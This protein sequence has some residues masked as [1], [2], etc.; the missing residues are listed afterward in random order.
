MWY[1]VNVTNNV[2][3]NNVAGWDGAGIS[4]QDALAVN[5]INNTIASNDTTASSGVL[6]NTLGAPLASS[7]GPTC[8]SNCGTTSKPQ[9][10]GVVSIQ[11]SAVLTANLPANTTCPAT[12][13]NC[14]KVSYPLLENNVFWQNRSFYIG[15]GPLGMGTLNQQNVVSLFNAFSNTPAA[16]QPKADATT[17]NGAG[18]IVTGGSGACDLTISANHFWDLGVRGDTGPENH[19]SGVTLNPTYSVITDI[20]A[21]T[22]YNANSA[23][24]SAGNPTFLSQYCNGSRV[25]PELGAMGYQV[26]PGISDAQVPNPV[27]NLT[28]AATIDEGNNWIN[29]SWGPLSMFQPINGKVLGNYGPASNS[30]SAVGRIPNGT[31]NYTDAPSLDYFGNSRK[32]GSVDAGA[33]EFAAGGGGGGGGGGTIAFNPASWSPTA[34]RGIGA[35]FLCFGLGPVGPCQAFTLTNNTGATVTGVGNGALGGTNAADYTTVRA[36]SS[37]GPAG[38][39]QI[40]ATTSLANGASCTVT[41]QFLPKSTDT[42]GTETATVSVT[43]SAGTQSATLSGTA[44]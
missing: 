18:V 29:L 7:S 11:N 22:G 13:P 27:F 32:N 5:I 23:H 4:L 25:P 17:T 30:S 12:H 26:P 9:P 40:F 16:S 31:Q 39:G 20:S 19:A 10:A 6:F 38:G 34:A 41:V 28:P 35:G 24:N 43:D 2:I 8:T 42:P 1:T 44:Q 21:A 37:C 33:V 15:V 36:L 14:K 3:T